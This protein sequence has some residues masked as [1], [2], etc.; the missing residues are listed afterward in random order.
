MKR[1]IILFCFVLFKVSY[2]WAQCSMCRAVPTSNHNHGENVANGLNTGIMYLLILPYLILVS[3]FFYFFHKP[4][5][6]WFNKKMKK[7]NEIELNK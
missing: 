4:I 3:L 5:M 6:E 2:L 7:G 1:I